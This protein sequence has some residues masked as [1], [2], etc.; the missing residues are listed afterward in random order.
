MVASP[1]PAAR[2]EPVPDDLIEVAQVLGAWGVR[3]WIKLTPLSDDAAALLRA[4]TWWLQRAGLPGS[5]RAHTVRLTRRQ[6]AAIVA[7]LE[8]LGDRD[9]AEALRGQRVL[10]RR[11]DFP[12]AED[13]SFYWVDLIGCTV[14]DPQGNALGTV[15]GLIDNAAHATLRIQ[16]P[17]DDAAGVDGNAPS[18]RLIPF[19]DAVVPTVDLAARRIVTTWDASY[20]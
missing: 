14:Y 20:F 13:G 10:V 8:G 15:V 9:Q 12:P 6:G 3:G 17:S 4:Q 11:A 16:P 5:P 7:L 19:V 1:S 2:A 18:E